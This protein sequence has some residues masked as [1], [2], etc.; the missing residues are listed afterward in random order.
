ML[1]RIGEIQAEEKERK[2]NNQLE[3]RYIGRR[4]HLDRIQVPASN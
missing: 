3:M 1:V 4:Y 2:W